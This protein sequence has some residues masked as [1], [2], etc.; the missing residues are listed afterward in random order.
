MSILTDV[1]RGFME[2]NPDGSDILIILGVAALL[3]AV[4]G[5]LTN[6]LYRRG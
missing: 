4:F 6:R 3:T 1:S 2:G 5:T